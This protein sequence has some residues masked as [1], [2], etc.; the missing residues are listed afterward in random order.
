MLRIRARRSPCAEDHLARLDEVV[1]VLKECLSDFAFA[2]FRIGQ[3]PDDGH[4]FWRSYPLK[5]TLLVRFGIQR[6]LYQFT[7]VPSLPTDSG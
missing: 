3:A 4:V 2:D 5:E 1:V 6:N 7:V